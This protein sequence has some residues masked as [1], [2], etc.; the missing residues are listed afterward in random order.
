M[1]KQVEKT[2]TLEGGQKIEIVVKQPTN[3]CA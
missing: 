1:A 2:V 3:R